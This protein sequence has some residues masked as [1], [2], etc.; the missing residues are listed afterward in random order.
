LLALIKRGTATD[1]QCR[2]DCKENLRVDC[3]QH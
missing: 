3:V 2:K 1:G